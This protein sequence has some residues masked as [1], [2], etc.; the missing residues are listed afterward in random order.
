MTKYKAGD[1]VYIIANNVSVQE[2]EVI[3]VQ[4]EFYT[5]RNLST[6]GGM[7]LRENRLFASL[8]EAERELANIKRGH[9]FGSMRPY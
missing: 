7:R 1:K 9:D 2:L 4:G 8:Y 6:Y 3:S 5:L